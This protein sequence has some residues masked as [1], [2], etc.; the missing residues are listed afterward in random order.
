M[1]AMT[2]Q[3]SC[4]TRWRIG[5]VDAFRPEGR[6]LDSRSSCHIGILGKSFTQGWRIRG[7]VPQ[8]RKWGTDHAS[9]P[10]I[11]LEPTVIECEAKFELT[12]RGLQD[13]FR[14][15]K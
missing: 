2:F 14:V 11:F 3:Q 6:E 8:N 15:V 7:T 13:E 9:V 5:K 4:L 10:P 1:V 12:K